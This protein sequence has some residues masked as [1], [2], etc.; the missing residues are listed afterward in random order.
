MNDRPAQKRLA[1]KIANCKLPE[2]YRAILE[3]FHGIIKADSS[4]V[5]KGLERVLATFRRGEPF[6]YETIISS[7][8]SCPCRASPLGLTEAA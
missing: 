2:S 8:R 5:A 1:P 6:D 4:L 7:P 3:T